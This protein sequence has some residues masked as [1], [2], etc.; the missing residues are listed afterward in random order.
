MLGY[1]P[2]SGS[3]CVFVRKKV[4]TVPVTRQTNQLL[5]LRDKQLGDVLGTPTKKNITGYGGCGEE[6][7]RGGEIG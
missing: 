3:G 4:S 7:E 5:G 1:T 6:E 2:K